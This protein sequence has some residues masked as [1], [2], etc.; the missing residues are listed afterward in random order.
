MKLAT[1]RAVDYW[2][3][4]PLCFLCTFWVRLMGTPKGPDKPRRVLFIELSEMGSTVIANPALEKAKNALGAEIFF[5]IF[6]RNAD[7]LRLLP[8]VPEQNIV[9][10]REDGLWEL[11]MGTLRILRWMRKAQIDTVV[12]MELFSRYSGLLTGLS[13]AKRRVGFHKFHAEGLY[14]GEM[15]TH[16]V[17]YN[18]HIHMAKNFI[19]MVNALLAPAPEVPYSKTFVSDEEIRVPIEPVTTEEKGSIHALVREVYAQYNPDV[20][21][22]VLINPNSSELLPQRR[23]ERENFIKVAELVVKEWDN[24]LV[25][26]TGSKSEREEALKMQDAVGHPRFRSFAGMHKLKAITALYNV[27]E[28]LVTNDSGPGHFSAIAPI[29]SIVLFGPETPRL[30]GSLGN[31]EAIWAGLSCSPCV[32][33]ANQKNSA[34]NDPVCMRM[35]TP[36]RVLESIRGV[37]NRTTPRSNVLQI[38]G[39]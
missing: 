39:V 38:T 14:R 33:A 25:L 23:W 21:R 20:H 19:C 28:V 13:G 37:L 16:R 7:S 34:C 29:R 36:E 12:D 18:G 2:I 3:G 11:A 24:A 4:I 5:L 6:E 26:I 22:I 32:T 9:T 15:L 27:A 35:I 10:I 1:M 31:S 8:T 17:N 30:Y